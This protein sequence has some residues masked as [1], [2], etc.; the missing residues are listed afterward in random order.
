MERG[1][2][3]VGVVE[4]Y[5]RSLTAGNS[6][7]RE[8]STRIMLVSAGSSL[9]RMCRLKSLA[10]LDNWYESFARSREHSVRERPFCRLH[11]NRH[12][13]QRID[14]HVTCDWN[15]LS[16]PRPGGLRWLRCSGRW[17]R[18][19]SGNRSTIAGSGDILGKM[20]QGESY[21]FCPFF[22]VVSGFRSHGAAYLSGP[23]H[24]A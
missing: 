9:R 13:F 17:L 1:K 10:D 16:L 2:G 20:G 14:E 18:Q 11:L 3:R 21:A 24:C 19:R 22:R 6:R 12:R 15:D 8:H 7:L 5:D 4:S 23:K